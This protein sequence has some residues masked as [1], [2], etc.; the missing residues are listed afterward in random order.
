[1]S[2]MVIS[3]LLSSFLY[4]QLI[5]ALARI[6]VKLHVFSVFATGLSVMSP[7]TSMLSLPEPVPRVRAWAASSVE[8]HTPEGSLTDQ[9][10]LAV[11]FTV[12]WSPSLTAMTPLTSGVA[13]LLFTVKAKEPCSVVTTVSLKAGA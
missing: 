3:V 12:I 8:Y 7:S 4:V 11:I 1:M 5:S 13:S 6:M 10:V 2:S 9:P